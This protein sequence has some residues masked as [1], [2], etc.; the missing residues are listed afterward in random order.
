MTIK[1]TVQDHQSAIDYMARWFW[2]LDT[3]AEACDTDVTV[4]QE[5]IDAK[6]VPGI[7][8][9]YHED[10]GWWSALAAYMGTAPAMPPT[11]GQ[12]WYSPASLWWLR[13]AMIMMRGGLTAEEAARKNQDMFGS[14]FASLLEN[15]PDGSMSFPQCFDSAGR[16]IDAEA[17]MA[18]QKEWTAWIIGG[19]A[20]CLRD[21]SAASCIR[22]EAIGAV[23][24]RVSREDAFKD[25]DPLEI[26]PLCQELSTLL[27][28]FA[29]WER[30]VGT[31][32]KTIDQALQFYGLG[33]DYPYPIG[34]PAGR[35]ESG[36][37]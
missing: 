10:S 8:Y 14:D 26:L 13:R 19:Y 33:D 4:V 35:V 11:R 23:L 18:A 12:R 29:P 20:V 22:K 32:G 24:K 34:E 6:C 17:R 21:F 28:P 2:P 5:M 36:C 31:P 37:S 16:I 15:T 9:H 3:L 1:L 30:P 25:H 27:T 7:I